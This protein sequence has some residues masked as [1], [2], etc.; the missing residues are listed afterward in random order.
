M[1]GRAM[2]FVA[3]VS[4]ACLLL[5]I[6]VAADEFEE[7]H[8]HRIP[9]R[10]T[11][12]SIPPI[13]TPGLCLYTPDCPPGSF[14]KT[15]QFYRN[16]TCAPLLS[17]NASCTL[18]NEC[19][20]SL[21]CTPR[22]RRFIAKCQPVKQPGGPC[23]GTC[24]E[25]FACNK[26][27]V[28]IA[29]PPGREGDRCYSEKNCV[30]DEGFSC[31]LFK[32]RCEKIRREGQACG[33][34]DAGCVGFCAD[35]QS[36]KNIGGICL[37]SR[38]PQAICTS[39]NQC[40][41]PVETKEG[42]DPYFC[43]QPNGSRETGLC[44]RRSSVLKTLGAKC[45]RRRDLCDRARD[46]RCRYSRHLGRNAC[47]HDPSI[48]ANKFDNFCVRNS[49]LS[50]CARTPFNEGRECRSFRFVPGRADPGP[51]P[52]LFPRCLRRREPVKLGQSCERE[53]AMC[54]Q[55]SECRV[56]LGIRHSNSLRFDGLD[57]DRA[58]Y[59][60][61]PRDEGES[62]VN[63]FKTMC[64]EGL[65]CE[66]GRCVKGEKMLPSKNSHAHIGGQCK[67]I[68]CTP[69]HVC[70]SETA[71]GRKICLEQVK[72][73]QRGQSCEPAALFA[74]KCATGLVCMTNRNNLGPLRCRPPHSVGE[75]CEYS[76]QCKPGLK[77]PNFSFLSP[78]NRRDSRCYHPRNA[79][80]LGKPC[81]PRTGWSGK[82]CTFTAVRSQFSLDAVTL[83]CLPK[84]KTFACQIDAG[85]FG[86]C[87]AKLN[88][89]CG[90]ERFA[91]SP[92]GVCVPKKE[93]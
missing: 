23:D 29:V 9:R 64:K 27:G 39:D 10:F 34:D 83:R 44:E 65:R 26:D 15:G 41:K 13:S 42:P 50:H 47:Q 57:P 75:Y 80:G 76:G 45:F 51:D 35:K 30:V 8:I 59:C 88:R 21:V 11:I 56:I 91:C 78:R 5:S 84:G 61:M 3:H 89:A 67:D 1:Q 36:S 70:R 48:K 92:L 85:P 22:D 46:L 19:R 4:L 72:I 40:P 14:C 32:N 86:R 43:N 60:V 87:D 20:T 38:K 77:C 69:G 66:A 17:A 18:P 7:E 82:R 74:R 2:C 24:I 93:I 62:C 52:P 16:Q 55:G 49:K 6:T 90:D 79:L 81:N 33:N 54:P 25:P 73:M 58:V 37:P 53:F 31:N 68:P 63:K 71:G 12:P 28:C